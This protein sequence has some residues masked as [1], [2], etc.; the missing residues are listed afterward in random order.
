LVLGAKGGLD[1]DLM[2]NVINVSSGR[3]SAT[4]DK[5][6][7]AVLPGTLDF[8]ATQGLGEADIMSLIRILEDWAGVEVRSHA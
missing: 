2:V 4:L 6:P 3:N 7:N 5:V 1:P 8:G